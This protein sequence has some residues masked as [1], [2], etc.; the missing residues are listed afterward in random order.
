M[1]KVIRGKKNTIAFFLLGLVLSTIFQATIPLSH[2]ESKI[3]SPLKQVESG[4][5]VLDIKCANNLVL[6]LK[7]DT[8]M[9][10]CVHKSSIT[11]LIARGWAIMVSDLTEN[12]VLSNDS[13][14]NFSKVVPSP[15]DYHLSFLVSSASPQYDDTLVVFA[16]YLK[17]G[18]SLLVEG[19]ENS[20]SA[21]KQKI[22]KI[23]SMVL[24][25]VNVK[26]I[27]IYN[28][29][30]DLANRVPDLPPGFS[31][32]GYDYEQGTGFSPEFTTNVTRSMEYFDQAKDA[33]FKYNLKTN[34]N[35]SL[36]I[37]PPFGQLGKSQW[38]WGLAGLHTDVISVQFQAFMQDDNFLNYVLDTIAKIKQ[39]SVSAKV[40]I[41]LSLVSSRG[42]PQDNLHAINM[43]HRLPINSFLVFYHPY[44]ISE[45]EKFLSIVPT[46]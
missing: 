22:Q 7:A 6:I 1:M 31:Y 45:L 2:A 37:M 4:S 9:P 23:R 46:K 15:R 26:P 27:R 33:V 38:D 17:P 39:E 11:P 21:I 12:R 29:I 42:T 20:E 3:S 25:G 13:H 30:D 28:N 40:M 24:S 19:Y 10:F 44:Q 36:I 35:A 16:K 34:G 43:L 14:G 18:D 8:A 41:Q 32:I 5:H